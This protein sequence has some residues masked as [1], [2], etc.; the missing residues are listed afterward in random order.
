MR[1]F[2]FLSFGMA[3]CVAGCG[4]PDL[5]EVADEHVRQKVLDGFEKREAI[6][7]FEKQG[8]FIDL[9]GSSTTVDRDVVLPLLKQLQEVAATEQWVTLIPNE[10]DRAL[11]LLIALPDNPHTVDRMAKVV[12]EADDKFPGFILQQWGHEWLSI[13]LIDKETYEFL[14]KSN[15]NLDKQR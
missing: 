15:P 8:R 5:Q 9:E 13:N 6:P 4:S 2:V 1:A 12:E 7:F 3:L 14:K 11:Y 10:K